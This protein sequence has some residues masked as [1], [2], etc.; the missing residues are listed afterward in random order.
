M[1]EAGDNFALGCLLPGSVLADLQAGAAAQPLPLT[2]DEEVE[3]S[4]SVELIASVPLEGSFAEEG[5]FGTDMAF[6]GR[7]LFDGNYNGFQVFDIKK[8]TAPQRVAQVVCPGGQ[9]DLSI[10]RD[11]LVLSV[12][13]SRSDDSCRSTPLAATDGVLGVISDAGWALARAFSGF[14]TWPGPSRRSARL[15]A[16]LDRWRHPMDQDEPPPASSAETSAA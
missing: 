13:S 16:A 1:V 5:A 14:D 15:E 8:P 11:I 6:Q 7:W 3:K 10:Y 2:S 9:A 4:D 12:D